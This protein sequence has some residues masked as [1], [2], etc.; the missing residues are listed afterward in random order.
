MNDIGEPATALQPPCDTGAE[1][2]LLGGILFL[3]GMLE[4]IKLQPSDFYDQRHARLFDII[5]KIARTGA[6]ADGV[7]VRAY[8][9]DNG[10]IDAIGGVAYLM[11][12]MA[13]GAP[14]RYQIID[15]ARLVRDYALRRKV[16]DAA[17]KAIQ[18]AM[19]PPEGSAAEELVI[20]AQR[21]FDIQ[22][23]GDDNLRSMGDAA[24]AYIDNLD[25]PA[26]KAMPTMLTKLDERLG[27]GLFRGDLVILAARPS[28]GK[29][30]LAN[31]IARNLATQGHRVG[32]TS[33]EMSAEAIAMRTLAAV[34]YNTTEFGYQRFSYSGLRNGAPGVDRQRLAETAEMLDDLPLLIDDRAGLS[35]QQIEWSARA[36]RRRLGGLDVLV[37]DYLQI[38][39]RPNARGRNTPEVLGE[40]T[41]ALKSLARTMGICVVLLS[42]LSRAVESRDDK[43][44]TLSDLR[45]SGAIEQDADVVMGIFR[46]AYYLERAEPPANAADEKMFE[47]QARLN[48][49]RDAI[50]V[51][52]LKQRNGPTGVDLMRALMGHDLILNAANASR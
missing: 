37:I 29:T 14:M 31:N 5:T 8:A 7:T 6:K 36:M 2:A 11:T 23:G 22:G 47:W 49:V 51:L 12:V 35:V 33:A 52:T 27:G 41:A 18:L 30:T 34:N 4:D 32:M 24:R 1:A 13:D 45:E 25:T 9:R 40:M 10:L 19:R 46:E 3:P 16:I 20:A 48:A 28:M 39:A 17:Q 38:L 15:Y 42:Q 50:E 26:G 21:G 43:R 44:P